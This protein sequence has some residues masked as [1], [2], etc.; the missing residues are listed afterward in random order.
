MPVIGW[1]YRNDEDRSFCYMNRRD[2]VHQ[3]R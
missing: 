3:P 1:T 2:F